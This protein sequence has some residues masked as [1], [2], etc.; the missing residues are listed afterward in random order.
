MNNRPTQRHLWKLMAA[1]KP[2]QARTVRL[3]NISGTYNLTFVKNTTHTVQAW[4][5]LLSCYWSELLPGIPLLEKLLTIT[6]LYILVLT[7]H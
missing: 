3:E 7:L 6:A 1:L 5:F 4:C 2:M